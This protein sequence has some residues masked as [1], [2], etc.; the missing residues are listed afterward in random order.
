MSL[1]PITALWDRGGEGVISSLG[2][3]SYSASKWDLAPHPCPSDANDPSLC[4]T[5]Q[6]NE[7]LFLGRGDG[8]KEG[9]R[10]K[11]GGGGGKGR[12]RW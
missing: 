12:L 4:T 2:Y 6:Q 11:W 5:Q 8:N 9:V 7:G 10:I 1:N 3:I